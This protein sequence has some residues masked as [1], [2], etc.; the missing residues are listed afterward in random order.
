MADETTKWRRWIIINS[1]VV[2]ALVYQIATAS[3]LPSQAVT[4][5]QYFLLACAIFGLVA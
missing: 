5:L 2:A 1:V 4:I 3:E